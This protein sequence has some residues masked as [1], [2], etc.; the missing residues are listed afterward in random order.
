MHTKQWQAVCGFVTDVCE[1]VAGSERTMRD[2]FDLIT[3]DKNRIIYSW[4]DKGHQAYIR[5][6]DFRRS[7]ISVA[8][9]LTDCLP[10]PHGLV[11]LHLGNSP[12]WPVCYWAILMSGHIP[13]VL[14][15]RYELFHY[16]SLRECSGAYCITEDRNYPNIISPDDLK[17]SRSEVDSAFFD[18]LWADETVFADEKPDGTMQAV[19]HNGK[20]I[21]EQFL[22]LQQVYQYNQAM[23]YPAQMGT[24]K[25]A[26]SQR[27][28]DF[29]GF[30]CGIVLYPCF[31]CELYIAENPGSMQQYL[32]VCK[33]LSVTHFCVS[34]EQCSEILSALMSRISREFPKDSDSYIAWLRGEKR[35]NDY[36][37]LSRYMSISSKIRKNV[38]GKKIRCMLCLDNSLDNTAS[39]FINQLG[40]FFGSGCCMPELGIISM[41]L[42]CDS[43]VRTKNSAGI[44]LKGIVGMLMEDGRLVLDCGK[45]IGRHYTP[46]GKESFPSPFP[47]NDKAAFD[48]HNRLCLSGNR[49][50]DRQKKEPADPEIIAKMR[51]LYATVLNKPVDIIEEDMDFF[52]ALGGD[53]LS[54]FLL[55]QHIEILFG[56]QIRP[57]ERIYFSTARY[58]AETLKPYIHNK[59]VVTNNA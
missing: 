36:R 4:D 47:V 21:S 27:F 20:S 28:S 15:S 35:I 22:R 43:E 42:S 38:F 30:L 39:R 12:F 48:Q 2:L 52:S 24:I 37:L 9:R 14:D 31:S 23:F 29:F 44:L 7:V 49:Q 40:V 1:S 50:P 25:M 45:N 59:G 55:L 41:E 54:Y 16:R 13:L 33:S 46:D 6:D 26:V 19:S 32:S 34:A 58:A 5:R 53:S 17:A 56:I 57:E 8:R 3:E 10:D 18:Q 51:E 11:G